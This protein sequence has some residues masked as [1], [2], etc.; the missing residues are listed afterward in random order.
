MDLESDL[1]KNVPEKGEA[2]PNIV[3][4]SGSVAHQIIGEFLVSLGTHEGYDEIAKNL[5][6]TLFTEK[7]T[8]TALQIAIFGENAL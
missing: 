8:E 7:S 5:K 3:H 4:G 6:L 1:S 2:V